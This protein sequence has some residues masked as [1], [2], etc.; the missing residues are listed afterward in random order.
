MTAPRI[1]DAGECALSVEFGDRIDP[2]LAARVHALD[3]ALAADLPEGVAEAVPTYRA[4]M[5]HYDPLRIGREALTAHLL[6]LAARPAAQAA[7]QGPLWRLPACHDPGLAPDLAQVAAATGLTAARAVALHAGATYTVAMFGFAPG[8]AYLS[9]LPP[10]LA[11]PRRATPRDCIPEGALIVA[12]GQAIVAGVPMP[13]GWHILGQTA[14]RLFH[15]GRA[16]PFLLAPGDRIAFDPVDAA[17]HAA[18]AA[19]AAAG[20]VVARRAA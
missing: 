10:A 11:L 17:T 19:R 7:L 12:G 5:V 15:P 20:E 14:E 1:L 4:L 9:G 16:R 3:A 8:W 13:S 18:L 6:C 2:V